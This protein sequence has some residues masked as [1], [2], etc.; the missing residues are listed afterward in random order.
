MS[1]ADAIER[2]RLSGETEAATV[3]VAESRGQSVGHVRKERPTEIR[4][5]RDVARERAE[6]RGTTV[7]EE[8]TT[9]A[10]T[11]TKVEAA[12]ETIKAERTERLG[13]RF[14]EMERLLDAAR[15]PLIKALNLAHEIDWGEEERELLNSTVDNIK[16]L[17]GLIDIAFAGTADVDWDVELAKLTEE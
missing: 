17:L 15:R 2:A 1:L 4:R 3:A 8:V 13:F 5:V 11:I 14:I 10:E 16:S 9:V 12:A 7:E 6:K